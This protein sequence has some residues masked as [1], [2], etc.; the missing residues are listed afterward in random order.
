M[1]I[2]YIYSACVVIETPDV[3][4]LCDP[5]FTP[6]AYD[7]SWFQYPVVDNPIAT[8]G[9]VDLV[10]VSHIHP[11]HYDMPFLRQYLATYPNARLVIG[12][13]SPP[14]LLGKMRREGFAP[15]VVEQT[16]IGGT[17][18]CIA[19][20]TSAKI[21]IDSA[22]AVTSQGQTILVMND[23]PFDPKQIAT[24]LKFCEGTSIE[25]ALLPYTGAG[26]YPQTFEFD[27]EAD[28]RNAVARKKKQFLDLFDRYITALQPRVAIPYAGQ[29]FL[30]GPLSQL[31]HLRGVTDAA[32]A[33]ALYPGRALVLADGGQAAYD[34]ETRTASE[35]RTEP[36]DPAAVQ[37]ALES[38]G[39]AGY[40]YERELQLPEDRA[41]PIL[42]LLE[43]AQRA[44]KR[45]VPLTEP[46]W[47]CFAP[48]GEGKFF[49]FNAA[50]EEPVQVLESVS[51]LEPRCEISIDRRYFFGLLTGLYHWNNAEVGS[52]YRSRRKPDIYKPEVYRLL[53]RLHV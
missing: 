15:S 20:N 51:H 6:G 42:P 33:A 53:D 30:G 5:W 22:L 26:P 31:N 47:L 14:F 7:G 32:E 37:K 29:Y 34:T 43:A 2:R 16:T 48:R 52:Q 45:R 49:C 4:I 35:V 19:P 50:G 27:T 24:L 1:R 13:Q 23:N 25:A 10:W 46:Y 36:Y 40:A 9:P 3:K 38:I 44:A 41:M 12:D 28:L 21:N 11:D 18:L 39:F 8:I 17:A